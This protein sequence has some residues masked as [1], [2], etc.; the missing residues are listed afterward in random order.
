MVLQVASQHK[1]PRFGAR[2]LCAPDIR[3]DETSEV[4]APR[5]FQLFLHLTALPLQV[6]QARF[7]GLYFEYRKSITIS[8][9][10]SS[11]TALDH[12]DLYSHELRAKLAR[13][14]QEPRIPSKVVF[15]W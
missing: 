9:H 13:S 4:G 12:A 11:K 7:T 3:Y 8:G 14:L 15:P 1:R 6:A 10:R 5:L 2:Q